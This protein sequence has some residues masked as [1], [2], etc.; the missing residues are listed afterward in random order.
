MRESVS[1]RPSIGESVPSPPAETTVAPRHIAD[2]IG[3][4]KVPE[5]VANVCWG[6]RKRNFLY[7]CGT[8]SLYGCFVGT[9]GLS[10]FG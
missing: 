3:K 4:I 5:T 6:R 10:Y 2:L 1:E 9:Q 7:I 8:T